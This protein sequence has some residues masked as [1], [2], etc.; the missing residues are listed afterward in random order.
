MVDDPGVSTPKP[1]WVSL[2]YYYLAALTGLIIVITGAIMAINAG[3]DAIFFEPVDRPDGEEFFCY[4]CADD[5]G[6]E[7]KEALKGALVALVG[8]PIFLWHIRHA[9]R[10]EGQA[11]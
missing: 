1:S 6:D 2:L 4:G 5:R 3:V 8:W 9:R 7:L 11:T 10:R